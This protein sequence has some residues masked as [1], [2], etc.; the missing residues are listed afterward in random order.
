[1]SAAKTSPQSHTKKMWL[2]T[3][4]EDSWH[5]CEG[6]R[7][8]I[9]ACAV[10]TAPETCRVQTLIKNMLF[11]HVQMVDWK[12]K[13]KKKSSSSSQKS[14][15]RYY[16]FYNVDNQILILSSCVSSF[17]FRNLLL[18]RG[19]LCSNF[20]GLSF[21]HGASKLNCLRDGHSDETWYPFEEKLTWGTQRWMSMCVRVITLDYSINLQWLL[22]SLMWGFMMV[23]RDNLQSSKCAPAG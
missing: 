18:M 13:R 8:I 1:M 20:K 7:F 22:S 5:V 21:H 16:N 19:S 11:F 9:W 17:E 14:R 12:K 23:S 4:R 6:Q 3:W 10:T 15:K 2:Q